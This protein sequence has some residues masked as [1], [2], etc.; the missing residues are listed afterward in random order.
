MASSNPN[1]YNAEAWVSWERYAD[2][3]EACFTGQGDHPGEP[4][5]GYR[6]LYRLHHRHAPLPEHRPRPPR[7]PP[8]PVAP[9]A[10]P[11][12]GMRG[13]AMSEDAFA[14]LL[15]QSNTWANQ[16]TRLAE[17]MRRPPPARP[18][19]VIAPA[20]QAPVAPRA[21]LAG[22]GRGYGQRGGHHGRGGFNGGRG[23]MHA[24]PPLV[25]AGSWPAWDD[26]A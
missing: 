22:R 9:G 16:I 1:D 11:F 5:E 19:T 23:R 14:A 18:I 6:E 13:V 17:N 7:G 20:P 10:P 8:A 24:P 15:Q 2:R 3:L 21:H 4:P 25:V 26:T 12:Q